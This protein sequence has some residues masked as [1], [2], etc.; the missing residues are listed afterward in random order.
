MA[1]GAEPD[2]KVSICAVEHL[3]C[4]ARLEGESQRSLHAVQLRTNRRDAVP[5]HLSDQGDETRA[6]CAALINTEQLGAPQA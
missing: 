5:Q 2:I 1:R 4:V 6:V 3:R